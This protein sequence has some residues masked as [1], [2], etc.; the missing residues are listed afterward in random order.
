MGGATAPPTRI[1]ER[2][3]ADERGAARVDPGRPPECEDAGRDLSRRELRVPRLWDEPRGSARRRVSLEAL[4]DP[5]R[6][7]GVEGLQ[8]AAGYAAIGSSG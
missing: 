2:R 6:A 8:A 7:Q 1:R 4:S 5:A 3:V